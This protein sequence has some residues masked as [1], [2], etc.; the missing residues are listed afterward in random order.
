MASGAVAVD[1]PRARDLL[2]PRR[3]LLAAKRR[4]PEEVAGESLTVAAE[5][6]DDHTPPVWAIRSGEDWTAYLA[7]PDDLTVQQGVDDRSEYCRHYRPAGARDKNELPREHGWYRQLFHPS[8]HAHKA[9]ESRETEQH[10]DAHQV[11]VVEYLLRR[12][13]DQVRQ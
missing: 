12:P 8:Q 7:Q 13:T 2:R 4:P 3:Y 10:E 6:R 9:A 1:G 11:G 5:E